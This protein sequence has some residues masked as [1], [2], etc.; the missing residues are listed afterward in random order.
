[1]CKDLEG[2]YSIL[3]RT[4][5]KFLVCWKKTQTT[6]KMEKDGGWAGSDREG[7]GGR[8]IWREGKVQNH[9]WPLSCG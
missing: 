2:D 4:D 5:H 1:M 6:R 8:G 9:I 3:G 7:E